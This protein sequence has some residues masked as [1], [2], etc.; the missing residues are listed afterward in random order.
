M[1]LIHKTGKVLWWKKFPF[2]QIS[3]WE[4]RVFVFELTGQ[5][6]NYKSWLLGFVVWKN[7]IR[8]SWIF[9]VFSQQKNDNCS[10]KYCSIYR[11]NETTERI[12]QTFYMVSMNEKLYTRIFRRE[13]SRT[14]EEHGKWI[15]QQ[16]SLFLN[17]KKTFKTERSQTRKQ[18]TLWC[19]LKI[20]SGWRMSFLRIR[21]NSKQQR[22]CMKTVETDLLPKSTVS[23]RLLN[24]QNVFNRRIKNTVNK[25]FTYQ[26]KIQSMELR[27]GTSNPRI[28]SHWSTG[29]N[30]VPWIKSKF[31]SFEYSL[32]SLHRKATLG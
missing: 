8:L 14:G 9:F 12:W 15:D 31:V 32:K 5:I 10:S 13:T 17:L 3:V 25:N 6:I 28:F 19:A 16:L 18:V 22:H 21:K 24:F 23:L 1:E 30:V 29:N 26:R 7:I 2:S 27:F 11:N 20:V 4:A